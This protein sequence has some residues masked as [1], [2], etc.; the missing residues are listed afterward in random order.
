V[1]Q[2]NTLMTSPSG[3]ATRPRARHIAVIIEHPAL[4]TKYPGEQNLS[5]GE[6]WL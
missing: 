5:N 1:N 6:A 3:L 4:L 2:H